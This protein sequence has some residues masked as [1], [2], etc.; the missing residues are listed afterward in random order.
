MGQGTFTSIGFGAFSGAS[1]R[2]RGFAFAFAV[3]LR[4]LEDFALDDFF[5]ALLVGAL[6]FETVF[7]VPLALDAGLAA[8][9]LLELLAGAAFGGAAAGFVAGAGSGTAAG[10]VGAGGVLVAGAAAGVATLADAAPAPAASSL[11]NSPA[12]NGF[13]MQS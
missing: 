12:M 4:G 10:A 2:L 6:R 5:V 13:A 8:A 3:V 11:P 9:F 7:F 1:A